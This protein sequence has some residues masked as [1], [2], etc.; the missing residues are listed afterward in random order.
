MLQT[1]TAQNESVIEY[2]PQ[3]DGLR[4]CAVF[5]VLFYHFIPM[6][7]HLD[8]VNIG[9]LLAFFFV[10]SSYLITKILLVSKMRSPHSGHSKSKIGVAFLIRRTLRIFPAYYFYLF[11]VFMAPIAGQYLRENAGM[12]FTYLIN[13]QMYADQNWDELTA[14]VWTLAVEEQF[15]LVWP[16]IILFTADKY[17]P[18]VFSLFVFSGIISRA[19]LFLTTSQTG[20]EAVTYDILTPTCLDAFGFGALLAYQHVSGKLN[21]PIW[22]KLLLVALPVWVLSIVF[23]LTLIDQTINRVVVALAAL[24]VIE[25]ANTGFKNKLGQF[26]QHKAV[27]YLAKIS[28]GIY[29]YHIFAAF[30]FWVAFDK[31]YFVARNNW[32]IDLTALVNFAALPWVGFFLY[33]GLAIL[34][35]TI[36]WYCL[37]RPINK[38][39]KAFMYT[40]SQKKQPSEPASVPVMQQSLK[41]LQ[42]EVKH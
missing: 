30:I 1:S 41:T 18:R 31:L 8:S 7:Q 22:K 5:V 32:G 42:S 33:T 9:V 35:A 37:E 24:V 6:Y 40:A 15:Y 39:R 13:F 26:L 17:L 28:Y 25:G 11:L 27:L 2:K 34:F 23:D 3:I 21:N 12:F 29:L 16:W 10:L 4:F 20:N 19:V 36:S 38:L 14:H